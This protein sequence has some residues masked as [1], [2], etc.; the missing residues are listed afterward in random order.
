M[1][2][3]CASPALEPGA[4]IRARQVRDR[5]AAEIT[6]APLSD[7]SSNMRRTASEEFALNSEYVPVRRAQTMPDPPS[8]QEIPLRIQRTEPVYHQAHFDNWDHH[9]GLV[10]NLVPLARHAL[11]YGEL[12]ASTGSLVDAETDALVSTVEESCLEG[13]GVDAAISRAGGALLAEKRQALPIISGDMR[14]LTGDAVVTSGGPF[15]FLRCEAIIYAVG[16]NYKEM[17][18]DLSRGD[19][20]LRDAYRAAMRR[21]NGLKCKTVA[22]ALVSAGMRRGRQSLDNVLKVAVQAIADMAYP[23]LQRVHLV[24]FRKP[25]QDILQRALLSLATAG[26]V[27]GAYPPRATEDGEEH[28][29]HQLA[30][31]DKALHNPSSSSPPSGGHAAREAVV[32]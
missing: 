22:F 19:D 7:A 32:G 8:P 29:A 11:K 17:D 23:G 6:E 21:A 14:C 1:P 18:D 12:V 10:D 16:P 25:E 5:C 13:A 31:V 15:G 27:D 26:A 2:D 9:G 28:L 4:P 30:S 24:A 3:R 20:L